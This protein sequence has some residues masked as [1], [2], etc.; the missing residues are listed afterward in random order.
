[1]KAIPRPSWVKLA[2]LNPYELFGATRTEPVFHQVPDR[3]A[4]AKL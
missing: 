1:M 4:S 3:P 2:S